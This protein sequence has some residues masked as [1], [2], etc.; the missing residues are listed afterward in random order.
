MHHQV[1]T[2][3]CPC[4]LLSRSTRPAAG[5]PAGGV[6]CPGS[7]M[8]WPTD[9]IPVLLYA[10]D[11]CRRRLGFAW[12]GSGDTTFDVEARPDAGC[13]KLTPH[14][15]RLLFSLGRHVGSLGT[16]TRHRQRR[17]KSVAGNREL[18]P[19]AGDPS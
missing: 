3:I 6:Q 9:M 13:A 7:N 15:L 11:H 19:V 14:S 10:T 8:P 4:D 17:T 2:V 12:L 16:A 18:P 1:P 5:F